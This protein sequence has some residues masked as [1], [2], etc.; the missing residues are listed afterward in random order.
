MAMS[1]NTGIVGFIGL[2]SVGEPTAL[3]LARAGSNAL[4]LTAF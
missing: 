4:R 3:N 1:N 2:G